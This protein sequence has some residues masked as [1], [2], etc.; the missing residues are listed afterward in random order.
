[1]TLPILALPLTAP[2]LNPAALA[3]AT[4]WQE[5]R[6]ESYEGKLA[7][8]EVIRDRTLLKYQSDGTLLGT[9][10]KAYQFSGW[11]TDDPNRLKA[12]KAI[13]EPHLLSPNQ[14]FELEACAAAWAEAVATGTATAKSAVLYHAA[15]M[16]Q[17]PG[18]S[19]RVK[20]VA[21]VG[22]HIFYTDPAAK[23]MK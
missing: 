5:A 18:W 15:S 21:R 10:F 9:L 1:M 4:I 2:Q 22:G 16:K 23:G 14:R 6:G 11:N 20:E 13:A 17:F 19:K 12:L 3:V 7:V 8:A